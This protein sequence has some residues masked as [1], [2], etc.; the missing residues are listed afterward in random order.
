MCGNNPCRFYDH[1]RKE[2]MITSIPK[3]TIE[4][5]HSLD[6]LSEKPDI[7]NYEKR[8]TAIGVHDILSFNFGTDGEK[9]SDENCPK[10][11]EYGKQVHRD[12]EMLFDHREPE[13]PKPEH[14]MIRRVISEI[15]AKGHAYVREAEM[16]CQL[17]ITKFGVMLRGVIDVI[18]GYG[19]IIEIHDWKTDAL[20]TEDIKHEYMVQLSVYAHAARMY[21]GKD[22]KCYLHYLSLGETYSFEPIPFENI[23][24]RVG[25]VLA[26]GE[27]EQ[28][29]PIPNGVE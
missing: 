11:M 28:I 7:G 5:Y 29:E 3:G 12:A 15:D 26:L 24:N 9:K 21:Y 17:P 4:D 19:D 16:E 27:T 23:E 8:I 10:G 13:D 1:L 18:V 2:R 25:E 14:E 20:I 6:T 22:V